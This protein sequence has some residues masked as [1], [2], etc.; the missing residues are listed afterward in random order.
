MRAPQYDDSDMKVVGE[1]APDAALSDD[2]ADAA[3]QLWARE[4]NNGNVAKAR[5]AGAILAGIVLSDDSFSSIDGIA[6]ED[7]KTQRFVL[8]NFA[9]EVGF[10][11]FLPNGIL[12]ETAQDMFDH[13]LKITAPEWYDVLSQT[14]A[15]SFY[16]LSIRSTRGAGIGDTFATLCGLP[17]NKACIKKGN[18][19]YLSV[20]A[21]I[22]SLAD[23]LNFAG[24]EIG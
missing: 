5:R 24:N 11:A 15:I 16:Y 21:R 8:A 6:D 9:V 13:T 17:E 18:A 3:A 20:L 2:T 23:S 4:K 22:K 14:G 19:L 12:S 1:T 10:D 7:L